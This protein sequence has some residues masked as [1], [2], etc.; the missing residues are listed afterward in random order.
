MKMANFAALR[1][2]GIIELLVLNLIASLVVG[3]IWT[4]PKDNKPPKGK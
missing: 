2:V 3:A 1:S 4:A